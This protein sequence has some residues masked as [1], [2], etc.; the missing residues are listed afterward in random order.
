MAD[1]TLIMSLAKVIIAAAWADGEIQFDEL[2]SLKDLLFALPTLTALQ[3]A[4]LEMYLE[5]PIPEG[6][7]A[8]LLAQLQDAIASADDKQ[9]AYETL[10][11]MLNADGV[12]TSD[13]RRIA[14]EII[15]AI[16]SAD[17]GIFGHL[18]R[19]LAG[20]VT[21]RMQT[22]EDLYSR[23]K[24]FDEFVKNKVYYGVRRR[25]D[26][27]EAELEIPEAT[28]QKL[29]LA[30]GLLARVARISEGITE[31][32]RQAIVQALQSGW[33]ITAQEA[34]VVADVA[35]ADESKNLDYFRVTREF[36]LLCELDE[37]KR[38]LD[39]L[40]AVAA[41]DGKVSAEEMDEIR[42]V[43]R[44]LKLSNET[45]VSAKLKIPREQRPE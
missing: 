20:S 3:W 6:E 5:T 42:E 33:G 25:L 34:E 13:E 1:N 24:Y 38:F 17:T 11:K 39:A 10:D 37:R 4:E 8:F 31:T 26:L 32:E 19:L 15:H 14:R 36:V 12:V 27:G 2:N 44:S 18:S 7:R 41:A 28:L 30:G 29:G 35:V 22:V 21:R 9:L 40:F 23:E 16:D 45:F 43:A